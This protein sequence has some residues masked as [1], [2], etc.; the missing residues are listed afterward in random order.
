MF[1]PRLASA[2]K[3]NTFEIAKINSNNTTSAANASSG[4][5][6]MSR[7][8]N[9]GVRPSG[10]NRDRFVAHRRIDLICDETADS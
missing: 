3:K 7:L 10:I 5:F 1:E 2:D 8:L 4:S 6:G 9:E